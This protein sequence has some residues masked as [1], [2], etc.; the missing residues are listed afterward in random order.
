L[1]FWVLALALDRDDIL[2]FARWLLWLGV[3]GAG[4]ALASGWIAADR[5]GHDA[6][7]HDLVHLHR[8]WMF[9][10]S[11]LGLLSAVLASVLSKS[12]L[13]RKLVAVLLLATVGVLTVGA[14]R[15]AELVFR[16]GVGVRGEA[17]PEGHHHGEHDL[18]AEAEEDAHEHAAGHKHAD[19][20]EHDHAD[21]DAGE[22]HDADEPHAHEG[23][24]TADPEASGHEHADPTH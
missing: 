6:P 19:A 9:V 14:D 21:D 20:G 22:H 3:L 4:A 1:L 8:N 11:G 23:P 16:Y 17:P 2:G 12:A 7:G 24:L 5:M 10:A 13:G 15:G 18:G